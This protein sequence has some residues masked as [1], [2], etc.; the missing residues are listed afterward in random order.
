MEEK[1]SDLQ[2]LM[3]DLFS[4]GA[5]LCVTFTKNDGSE[6]II[7]CTTNEKFIPKESHPKGSDRSFA[8]STK[9]VF[10]LDKGEWRSFKWGNVIKFNVLNRNG[11]YDE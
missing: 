8:K 9:R 3:E 6:R 11:E 5:C 7:N 2:P 1:Y 10:D 4:D